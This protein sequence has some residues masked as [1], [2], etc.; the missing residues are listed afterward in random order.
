MGIEGRTWRLVVRHSDPF[1]LE[2]PWGLS[3]EDWPDTRMVEVARGNH[4]HVVRFIADGER[5]FALK[6]LPGALAMREYR[7][8]RRMAEEGLPVVDVVGVVQREGLP[9]VLITR[10]LD[11]SLPYRHLYLNGWG[12]GVSRAASRDISIQLLD[13][14]SLLL[15][16]LHLAG[17]FWGDCSLN[18]TLLKRDAGALAAYVVD[19]ETGE[20]H[21]ELTDGQRETDLEIA[22]TNLAGGLLDVEAELG[23]DLGVDAVDAA[24]ALRRSYTG[25]WEELTHEVI[26]SPDER[27]RIEERIRRLNDLGFHVDE[28]EVKALPSGTGGRLRLRT[29]VTE[30]GHH[31][32]R[33]AD[34]TGIRAQENQARTLLN[35]MASYRG[36]LEREH[37]RSLPTSAVAFRWLSEVY[38]PTV[39]AIPDGLRG[40]REPVEVFVE[41][42]RWKWLRSE[43]AGRDIGMP[44]ALE[45]YLRTELPA[46]SDEK[47]VLPD[48]EEA[49][50]GWIGFG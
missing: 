44:D 33:L 3:L 22:E 5:I 47:V 19:M 2:R 46:V 34:L 4:R 48:V 12:S 32:R 14:L 37:G 43:E 27:F 41:L 6:E 20:Q 8:L 16:R 49:D 31:R 28:V 11:F 50:T 9:D 42:L 7:L 1:L 26:V 18:N 40:K 36:W 10:Y 21:A 45:G 38:E 24:S 39:A 29:S 13:A 30:Q 23:V 15:V 17:Y 35:D 25:L